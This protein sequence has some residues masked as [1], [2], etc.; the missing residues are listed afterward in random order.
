M[1]Q[2][3]MMGHENM[4][5]MMQMMMMMHMQ[6][7]MSNMCMAQGMMGE[8]MMGEGMMGEGMM[9]GGMMGGGQA[10]AEVQVEADA[11]GHEEHSAELGGIEIK[12]SPV[13]LNDLQGETLDFDVDL[14][15]QGASLDLDVAKLALLMVGG[16]EV[17]ASSWTVNFDH[18]HHV[19]GTL[20]FPLAGL[21]DEL[22]SG[23]E[24]MLH[25][26]GAAGEGQ[27][28]FSWEIAD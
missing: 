14:E 17:A 18:G 25:M 28:M 2:G 1:G 15:A 6:H 4:Q 3:G 19:N 5:M 20:S 7:M 16:Q 9:G 8:G 10:P 12:V 11:P 26:N 21:E 23:A 24:I 13:N 22:T 27:A